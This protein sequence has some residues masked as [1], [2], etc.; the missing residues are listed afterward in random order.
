MAR[1][2]QHSFLKRQKEMRR[3]REAA[4]KMARRQGK[5]ERSKGPEDAG[6]PPNDTDNEGSP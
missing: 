1:R 5:A 6:Q 2:S 4:G 3:E